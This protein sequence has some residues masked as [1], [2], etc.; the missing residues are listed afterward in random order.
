MPSRLVSKRSAINRALA[1]CENRFV[2][3]V[4]SAAYRCHA[5]EGASSSHRGIA[6]TRIPRYESHRSNFSTSSA[7]AHQSNTDHSEENNETEP[8]PPKKVS[9]SSTMRNMVKPFFMRCHPDVQSSSNAK[10]INLSAIQN[11]NAFLDSV[12][13]RMKPGA[14]I[15]RNETTIFEV[16]FCITIEERIK[17]KK[18][19]ILCRR[20]V[21]LTLPKPHE[22]ATTNATRK[23]E[24]LQESQ[25]HVE[26]QL[27]KLLHI[28]NLKAPKSKVYQEKTTLEEQVGQ[29]WEK[30]LED[31]DFTG[32]SPEQIQLARKQKYERNRD[33]FVSQINWKQYDTIYKETAKDVRA[34]WAVEGLI[35]DDPKRRM[36]YLSEILSRM[37]VEEPTEDSPEGA[38]EVDPIMQLIAFRRLS[39]LLDEHFDELLLEDLGKMW[40]NTLIVLTP[41]RSY[42]TSRSAL[43]KRRKRQTKGDV[44]V[45]DGFSFALH[46]DNS[47]TI[48]IPVDFRDEEL[49]AQMKRHVNDYYSLIDLG[50]EGIFPRS[51]ESKEMDDST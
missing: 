28:A 30:A 47:V 50:L 45:N 15:S 41:A 6:C 22:I 14:R 37:R 39:L 7:N 44:M 10:E 25:F 46:H 31:G 42:N 4:R 51:A 13:A 24:K 11:L 26:N 34:S 2:G 18:E 8:K 33:A 29:S 3:N 19:D 23:R 5:L 38:E 21:E 20:K 9:F 32:L 12:E 49:L 43:Y 40:D 36:A 16:D 1:A 48:R 27:V 17:G 35:R